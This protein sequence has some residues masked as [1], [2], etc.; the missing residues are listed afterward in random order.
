MSDD[1]DD[2][3][4]IEEEDI[5]YFRHDN[6]D[7]EK[8]DFTEDS[9]KD[10]LPSLDENNIKFFGIPNITHNFPDIT[11]NQVESKT[12]DLKKVLKQEILEEKIKVLSKGRYNKGLKYFNDKFNIKEVQKV[13]NLVVNKLSKKEREIYDLP[14]EKAIIER[15]ELKNVIEE[16]KIKQCDRNYTI[17]SLSEYAGTNLSNAYSKGSSVSLNSLEKLEYLV[18]RKITH[19]IVLGNKSSKRIILERSTNLAEL[20]GFVIV[21]GSI[22]IHKSENSKNKGYSLYIHFRKRNRSEILINHIK[23]LV[24]KLFNIDESKIEII[25]N[26]TD[27]V[28]AFRIYSLPICY[29]LFIHGINPDNNIVPNW[30]FDKEE[31]IIHCLKGLFNGYGDFDLTLPE[32]K[33]SVYGNFSLLFEKA[34]PFSVEIAKDYKKLCDKLEIET[35]KIYKRE[36][37]KEDPTIR[38]IVKINKKDS[39]VKFLDTIKPLIWDIKKGHINEFFLNAG[40]N[41]DSIF[42]YNEDYLLQ[43]DFNYNKELA[44]YLLS[45]FEEYGNYDDVTEVFNESLYKGTKKPLGKD[46]IISYIKTLFEEGD[47]IKCYGSEGYEQWYNNNSRILIGDDLESTTIPH[48]LNIQIFRETYQ[49]LSNN[50][51]DIDNSVVI[52]SVSNYFIHKKMVKFVRTNKINLLEFGRFSKL[53]K[54]ISSKNLFEHYFDYIIK[55]IKE[56]NYYTEKNIRI[57]YVELANRYKIIF[58]HHQHVKQII[59]D[60]KAEFSKEFKVGFD[61]N[62][63]WHRLRFKHHPTNLLKIKNTNLLKKLVWFF[64]K[65]SKMD[66]DVDIFRVENPRCS[67]FLI[68]GSRSKPI[69]SE[70]LLPY[71]KELYDKKIIK[72]TSESVLGTRL[73]NYVNM[74]EHYYKNKFSQKSY[75]SFLSDEGNIYHDQLQNFIFRKDSDIIAT[76]LLVWLKINFPLLNIDYLSGHIDFLFFFNNC[77]YVCDYKPEHRDRIFLRSIPQISAYGL[78]LEKMMDLPNLQIKCITFNKTNAWEYEPSILYIYVKNIISELKI[79]Y[80][81]DAKWEIYLSQHFD[82]F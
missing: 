53:L 4:D 62:Y 78:L 42:H 13:Q 30:I 17:K 6:Q 25:K 55:F 36:T 77:L 14:E 12:L 32:Y 26:E 64:E 39:Y 66:Y 80:P 76:E 71:I 74:A 16:I 9:F 61:Q 40:I 79:D 60:L 18:N 8:P 58:Y 68:T 34:S 11:H 52:K 70:I 5:V 72:E 63:R 57:S 24:K 21:S 35:T 29:E 20:I 31:F 81:V 69:Q 10:N 23:S 46:R 19:T 75:N 54:T 41:P 44:E 47:Y 65:I 27:K 67:D 45:L 7:S 33:D 22:N 73:I 59:E 28:I 56:I 37:S 49:I 43:Q 51:F 15:E 38:V 3:P 50:L 48:Y 2:M 82:F 1:D